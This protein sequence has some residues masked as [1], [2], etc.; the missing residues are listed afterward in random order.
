MLT[1]PKAAEGLVV[2]VIKA[3]K[4]KVFPIYMNFTKIMNRELVQSP[5]A[6][7]LRLLQP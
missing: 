7:F 6:H 1:F 5:L 2:S 4:Y 3:E